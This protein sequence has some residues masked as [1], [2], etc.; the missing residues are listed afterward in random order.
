MSRKRRWLFLGAFTLMLSLVAAACGEKEVIK[1]VPVQVQEVTMTA[2]CRAKPPTEDW[3]C[4]NF[5]IAVADVNLALLA[6]GDS[7]QIKLNIILDDSDLID[8][9]P[10]RQEFVLST[11]AGNPPDI[12]LSGHEDIGEWA[13]NGLII[14][15]DDL[16]SGQPAVYNNVIDGLWPSVTFKGK[17]WAIPQDAEARPLYWSKPL[18]REL[19]L[20]DAQVDGLADAIKSGAYTLDDMLAAAKL[21]VDRGIVEEGF[22]F[23]HRPRNGPDFW[24]FYYNFGGETIDSASG[25]LVYDKAAGLKHFQFFEDA[26]QSSKVLVNDIFGREWSEWHTEIT[27]SNR[28]LFWIGG[29][30]QWAEWA[31][32]FVKD[33]GGEDFLWEN[34]GFGLIPAA[35]KGGKPVT[36]T[37][38]LAYMVSAKSKHPDLAFKLISAITNDEANTRHA[39]GSTHLGILKSQATYAP[40]LEDRLLSEVLYMLEF[41]TFIPNNPNWGVYNSA[42]FE[43]MQAVESG[44]MTAAE[45]VEFVVERM[46]AELGDKV[47]IR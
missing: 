2:R 24:A 31:E 18:L 7:R 32:I 6:A 36:L 30:W 37:H 39:V 33:R 40:Y 34:F 41:T 17:R 43:G 42:W 38:P 29:S 13:Q 9:D 47:I 46:Q 21:A 25:K 35:T 12:I 15:L 8:W 20:S 23:W 26:T 45:A 19:G 11:D 22:G 3:R 27:D 5:K 16:I 28:V 44:D 4:N 14:A 10:Y 1:E